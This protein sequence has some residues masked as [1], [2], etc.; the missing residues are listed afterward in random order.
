M[1]R[2]RSARSSQFSRVLNRRSPGSPLRRRT[3]YVRRLQQVPILPPDDGCRQEHSAA[4]PFRATVEVLVRP[5]ARAAHYHRVRI[6][7][8]EHSSA[9]RQRSRERRRSRSVLLVAALAPRH[10]EQTPRTTGSR[11]PDRC[12]PR[13]ICQ[14]SRPRD[15]YHE[16]AGGRRDLERNRIARSIATPSRHPMPTPRS[17][18]KRS[19]DILKP[20][21][22]TAH[23]IQA[24]RP[25]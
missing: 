25:R 10:D 8:V 20:N 2:A 23:V 1:T 5:P 11:D 4:A 9:R 12:T 13:D 18:L 7:P 17:P 15:A 21:P 22:P 19:R 3:R 6:T 24:G 16:I 14:R